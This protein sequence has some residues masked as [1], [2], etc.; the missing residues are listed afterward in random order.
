MYVA[1]VVVCNRVAAG[2]RVARR[3][4]AQGG[5]HVCSNRVAAGGLRRPLEGTVQV[6]L[7]LI[8]KKNS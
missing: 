4:A 7:P 6:Y 3:P 5:G 8:I 2:L 1:I